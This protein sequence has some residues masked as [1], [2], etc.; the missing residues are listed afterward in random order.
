MSKSPLLVLLAWCLLAPIGLEAQCTT[1]TSLVYNDRNGRLQLLDAAPPP[2]AAK[3]QNEPY[4]QYFWEFGDGNYATSRTPSV[5]Y[6][7]SE[8]GSYPVRVSLT[9]YYSYASSRQL[10][11]T[12][13]AARTGMVGPV[14]NRLA[15]NQLVYVNTNAA[16]ELIP[17][18]DIQVF[19]HFKLPGSANPGSGYLFL[20]FNKQSELDNLQLDFPPLVY[21][22]GSARTEV[23]F[24]P[25]SLRNGLGLDPEVE[26]RLQLWAGVY[27]YRVWRVN[28][29][30]PGRE[31]VAFFT[32]AASQALDTLAF[33]RIEKRNR[34][35]NQSLQ[36]SVKA[37]FVPANATLPIAALDNRASSTTTLVMDRVRDP[38][39]LRT[40]EPRRNAMVY[41]PKD[42]RSM[43]YEIQ[44]QNKGEAAARH[45][46]LD[47]PWPKTLDA[48]TISVL[49]RDPSL[50][51]GCPPCT[52][53]FDQAQEAKSCF[54]VD[55][56]RL[57]SEGQVTFA[58]YNI[59]LHGKR[60]E[61]I[62]KNRYT[63]GQV[64]FRVKGS[65]VKADQHEMQATIRFAGGGGDQL[66]T[67]TEKQKWI[68]RGF[69]I[70]AAYGA[71]AAPDGYEYTGSGFFDQLALGVYWRNTPLKNGIGW[72][73][74]IE[75]RRFDFGQSRAAWVE[76][77]LPSVLFVQEELVDMQVIDVQ[78]QMTLRIFPLLEIGAGGGLSVP[79][80]AEGT[81]DTRFLNGNEW[82]SLELFPNVEDPDYPR[83]A[84]E[85]L[86]DALS[87]DEAIVREV[88][89]SAFG[90]FNLDNDLPPY[91]GQD[92]SS[93]LG[94]GLIG[95]VFGEVGPLNNLALGFRYSWRIYPNSYRE[96]CIKFNQADL[97]LRLKLFSRR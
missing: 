40:L 80:A 83:L 61:G 2:G 79:F 69:G 53:A 39:R 89:T 52:I 32:F 47:V 11:N 22:T 72:G 26:K 34:L 77:D 92:I 15:D 21:R 35:R 3:S 73:S 17:N 94:L 36:L 13:R 41:H 46:F 70:I 43:E 95:Q 6:F 88:A 28:D 31:T 5:T 68:H 1:T 76:E 42:P 18:N 29:L 49:E 87:F 64:R 48:S 78:A 54:R 58:F 75:Y 4:W 90:V 20:F 96:Q 55:T 12:I 84:G 62:N 10:C 60:E 97:Y 25:S 71:E 33:S 45:V 82:G 65:G 56:S 16:G 8:P 57:A 44:F 14:N 67:N 81:L 63:K 19:T 66:Q 50:Q 7:Y 24:Q 93:G 37:V 51:D 30:Q 38:N 85:E 91:L 59:M 27:D 74:S 86:V 23:D 9:P